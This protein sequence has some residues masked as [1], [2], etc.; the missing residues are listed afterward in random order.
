LCFAAGNFVRVD[1]EAYDG[2]PIA[3]LAPKDPTGTYSDEVLRENL[4][5]SFGK[6]GAMMKWFE[7]RLGVPFPFKHLKYFQI[8]GYTLPSAMEYVSVL[9]VCALLQSK[10]NTNAVGPSAAETPH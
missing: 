4:K 10:W 2:C 3:Y 7:S 9:Y 6:T 1:D 5:L 8:V